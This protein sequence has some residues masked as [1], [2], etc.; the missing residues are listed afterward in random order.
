MTPP[1][2]SEEPPRRTGGPRGGLV[3]TDLPPGELAGGPGSA[4]L[5][6][7]AGLPRASATGK[8]SDNVQ[9]LIETLS[10]KEEG[11]LLNQKGS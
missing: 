6:E 3:P 9:L 11:A 8:L 1:V 7:L 10:L 5:G 2:P 4:W